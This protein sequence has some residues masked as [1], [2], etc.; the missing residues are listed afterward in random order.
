MAQA[1]SSLLL[2][3]SQH[4]LNLLSRQ[5]F[6]PHCHSHNPTTRKEHT[7]FLQ[8]QTSHPHT[9]LVRMDKWNVLDTYSAI[10]RNKVL[11][12]A[13]TWMNFENITPNERNQSQKPHILYDSIYIGCVHYISIKLLKKIKTKANFPQFY[14]WL[15]LTSHRLESSHMVMPTRREANKCSLYPSQPAS[16]PCAQLKNQRSW[17]STGNYIQHV[18]ITYNGKESE[19]EYIIYMYNIYITESLCWTPETDTTL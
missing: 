12:H 18:V 10:K 19:K 4:T 17:Y 15:P 1:P 13:E 6:Q 16:Q 5:M 14:T 3:L 2:Y 7:F 11:I 8:K 9:L